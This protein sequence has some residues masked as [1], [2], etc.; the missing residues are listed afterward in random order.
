MR[1]EEKVAASIVLHF[2][3]LGLRRRGEKEEKRFDELTKLFDNLGKKR[4]R[5]VKGGK[6]A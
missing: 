1:Y 5:V 3:R 6:R 2:S 4:L